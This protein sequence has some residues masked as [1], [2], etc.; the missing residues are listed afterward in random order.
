M[1]APESVENA[2]APDQGLTLSPGHPVV[3][4]VGGSLFDLPGLGAR[5]RCWLDALGTAH[6]LLVPGG[7]PTADVIRA[8]DRRHGLGQEHA[9]W[10][11][12][13]A[14]SL[15][16]AILQ[17]LVPGT[18][19]LDAWDEWPALC[20]PGLVPIVDGWRFAR[21]DEARPGHLPHRWEV[22]SDSL[23]ARVAV[24]ARAR[25]L[26]LLKSVTIPE[27][28]SWADAARCGYVDP[29]FAEACRPAGGPLS[30]RA[31]NFRLPGC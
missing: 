8:L 10:L 31:V 17:R 14:L 15:N 19:V 20:R 28:M 25:Q 1:E 23:A 3:V 9:H 26:I 2:E 30:V 29:F 16:A 4:K 6:V 7:G 5:L 22:T 13:Q 12:L 18:Q 24:V 11:A 21:A 27:T